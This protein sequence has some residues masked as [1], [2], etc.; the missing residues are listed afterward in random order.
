MIFNIIL[1]FM[2]CRLYTWNIL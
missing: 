1:F 2:N